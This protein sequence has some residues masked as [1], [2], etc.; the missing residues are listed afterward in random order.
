[1]PTDNHV[2]TARNVDAAGRSR[3]GMA[4]AERRDLLLRLIE[5][6]RRSRRA[7]PV[8]FAQLR[9]WFVCSLMSESW[10][11]NSPISLRLEGSLRREALE[12]ALQSLVARHDILR[13]SFEL[14]EE[15]GEPLQIIHDS[16][17]VEIEH[18][19][20]R[21]LPHDR[22][23]DEAKRAFESFGRRLFD[24]S[25]AP[26]LRAQLMRYDEDVHEFVLVFHHIVFDGWSLEVMYRELMEWYE[27]LVQEREPSL[28][29][30]TLPYADF[31]EWQRSYLTGD[32]LERYLA[33]W[34]AFLDGMPPLELPTDRLRLAAS[35]PNGGKES[36]DL[37]VE[38][39]QK[40]EALAR[41]QGAT[42]YMTVLAAFMLLVRRYTGQEDIIVG[43]PVSGRSH[44]DIENVIGCFINTVVLRGDLTG[45]PTFRQLVRR[46]RE[47]CL[48]V[49]EHQDLPF[50]RLVWAL[51]PD[52]D[53]SRN[54]LFNVTFDL[55]SIDEPM[56]MELS[57][58]LEVEPT[59]DRTI[60]AARFDI[61]ANATRAPEQFSLHITY[62]TDVFD[63]S[64]IRTM[65]MHFARI[66]HEVGEDPDRPISSIP[67][68][69]D[70]ERHTLLVA[71]NDT[72][73]AYADTLTVPELVTR[74][75]Q[76]HPERVAIRHAASTMSYA[77]LE[78][79]SDRL[80]H[81]LRSIG[82]GRGDRVGLMVG[83][84]PAMVIGLLGIQKA[85]AAYVPLDPD[86]PEARLRL[87]R[88]D[89]ALKTLVTETTIDEA[90]A[91][92]NDE[93]VPLVGAPDDVAY[94]IYTS[95]STGRPKGVEILQRGVVNFLETMRREPG[96]GA[97]DVLLAVTTLS[98][99]IAVLELLLPLVSGGTLVIAGA[100]DQRD[101]VRL[102]QLLEAHDVT[103]M[104]GTPATWQMMIESGWSGR[105][106]LKILCGGEALSRPLANVLLERGGELWNMYG[107][108]ETTIW[109]AT[110]RV[111][112]DDGPIDIGRPIANTQLY[113][114]DD[115][116]RPTPPGAVGELWIGGAGVA[117]GYFR[118]PALTAE[119]F[120]PHPFGRGTLYRT[121]DLVRY[122]GAGR[123]Q[124]L[125]RV[126]HQVKVRGF[127]IEP[128]EVESALVALPTVSAAAV[129]AVPDDTGTARL[130]A[131]VV[132]EED[133]ALYAS[134]LRDALAT[135]LPA[136][137]VPGQFVRL[138]ALPLNAN[139]KVDR[140]ALPAAPAGE[141][142]AAY[143]A[144]RTP[145]E[146]ALAEIWAPLLR[147]E[148]IGID[149]RFFDLGGHSLLATRVMSRIRAAM[150]V[151]LPLAAL[152]ERPT[153]AGL[154]ATI[155]AVR[156]VARGDHEPPSRAREEL[157]L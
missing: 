102:A 122:D 110:T 108:T 20:L 118:R 131:Y 117:R 55:M 28:D 85:G 7:R 107:P 53:L 18:I 114:V 87:M 48:D 139:G 69:D 153:I 89:A 60:R 70:A 112:P 93:P 96:F 126:D 105:A 120:V 127:R 79:A 103:V 137:M 88:E 81:R 76:A 136:Y 143:I 156:G 9:L 72:A 6:R 40:L 95:G 34:R 66:L 30:V 29:P 125:G 59:T 146:E 145:T 78:D 65:L 141:R 23:E 52:R 63:A 32:V 15:S 116:G 26:L 149:D 151:A 47:M 56:S 138:E 1:M 119:R 37:T 100:D 33:F 45:Q 62:R 133:L 123:L 147:L 50:E 97:A 144:P 106:G 91:T 22:R 44:P 135:R 80:A 115:E 54:P 134:A 49:F 58:G 155:D 4:P 24:L 84:S 128:G 124:F 111:R 67:L 8:S 41:Q 121:G 17:K 157:M 46:I 129:M 43:A 13:T 39:A 152:F 98:F 5:Q 99:D 94:V 92:P 38:L 61:E 14:D 83:R 150:G 27:A 77:E 104:Q 21:H 132:T 42:L 71:R 86:L 2:E 82:I 12:A 68:M 73:T 101:G 154:A 90:I 35:D 19:D 16:A 113:I 64:T 10:H 11:Y 109:S 75:A 51:D 148:R 3:Q 142:T 130:V 74:T 31:A 140:A 25:R 57:S 36:I